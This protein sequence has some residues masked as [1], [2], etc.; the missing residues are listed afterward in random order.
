MEWFIEFCEH[1]KRRFVPIHFDATTHPAETYYTS[2]YMDRMQGLLSELDDRFPLDFLDSGCGTGRFL[3]PFAQQGHRMTAI[4][5][6]KDS[7][8]IAKEHAEK[9]GVE[10]DTHDGDFAKVLVQFEDE[11]FDAA[12]SLEAL[13]T[14][15]DRTGVMRELVRV[16]RPGGLLF[17]THR[18][19]FYYLMQALAKGAIDD[20]LLITQA[21]EGRLLKK[22]HRIYYNWQSKA[23]IEILYEQLGLTIREMTGIGPYSGCESDPKAAVCDPGELSDSERATLKE[24]ELAADPETMM[25]SRYVL[26]AAQ[27]AAAKS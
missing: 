21:S 6:H 16:L 5:F 12:M 17:V 19:R 1:L 25:A 22:L 24:V 8:R 7:L 3:I 14:T 13:Y 4:D 20:A 26:V 2:I 18:T 11:S 23:E 10:I 27:K 15:K 9:V